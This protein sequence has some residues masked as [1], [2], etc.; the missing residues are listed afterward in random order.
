ML[1]NVCLSGC[2]D[3]VVSEKHRLVKIERLPIVQKEMMIDYV[4]VAFW[5]P[6]PNS[7]LFKLPEGTLVMITGRLERDSEIGLYVMC[8]RLEYIGKEGA[9]TQISIV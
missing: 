9:G 1:S 2:L 5:N 8:E 3:A 6:N 4:P 7:K